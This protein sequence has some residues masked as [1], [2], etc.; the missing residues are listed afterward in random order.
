MHPFFTVGHSSRSFEV[1]AELSTGVDI[2]LVTD[3]RNVPISRTNPQ[4]NKDTF[5]DA[6]AVFHI[7][8]DQSAALGVGFAKKQ[9]LYL[10]M[11]TVSGRMRVS[12]PMPIMRVSHD[13][14][15]AASISSSRGIHGAARSCVRKLY[16]GG[17]I[18]GLSSI[19]LSRGETC[20]PHYGRAALSLPALRW[21]P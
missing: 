4:F 9:K 18:G 1:C 14:T 2:G 17:V 3:I 16:D 19:I 12:I 6:L 7:L 15:W 21:M 11:S 10:G 5:A 13:F 20:Y 8:Y